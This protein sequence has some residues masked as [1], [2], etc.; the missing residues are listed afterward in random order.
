MNMIC[1]LKELPESTKQH[2]GMLLKDKK[3]IT[4]RWRVNV[5]S[6]LYLANSDLKL[7]QSWRCSVESVIFSKNISWY[8]IVSYVWVHLVLSGEKYHPNMQLP[9]NL[10]LLILAVNYKLYNSNKKCERKAILIVCESTQGKRRAERPCWSLCLFLSARGGSVLK[11]DFK[12][13]IGTYCI[14]RGRGNKSNFCQ[15]TK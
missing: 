3:C 4:V 9:V 11:G 14:S 13:G 8:H 15:T 1:L 2:Y 7:K 5:K 6:L 12:N 10:P